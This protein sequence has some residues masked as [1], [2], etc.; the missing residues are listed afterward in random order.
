[1]WLL[2]N[3]VALRKWNRNILIRSFS[4]NRFHFSLVTRNLSK[5]L[6]KIISLISF[7]KEIESLPA[8]LFKCQVFLTIFNEVSWKQKQKKQKNDALSSV[9]DI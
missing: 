6:K 8:E 9:L 3:M 5:Q 2:K 7:L 1:M 4:K